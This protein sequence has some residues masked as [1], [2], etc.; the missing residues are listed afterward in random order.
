[1]IQKNTTKTFIDEYDANGTRKQNYTNDTAKIQLIEMTQWCNWYILFCY[2]LFQPLYFFQI[3]KLTTTSHDLSDVPWCIR[4]TD[5]TSDDVS[6][7]PL[8]LAM[9]HPVYQHTSND[10]SNVPWRCTDDTSDDVPDVP[11]CFRCTDDTSYNVPGAPTRSTAPQRRWWNPETISD[12]NKIMVNGFKNGHGFWRLTRPLPPEPSYDSRS[13]EPHH[14]ETVAELYNHHDI[15]QNKLQRRHQ[16][17]PIT[18]TTTI[19]S[20]ICGERHDTNSFRSIM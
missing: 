7:V 10:V 17:I 1:M 16:P 2:I 12:P 15:C 8:T 4:C 6:D 20:L 14:L 19:W 9:M 5:D 13:L 3:T 11:W 18:T